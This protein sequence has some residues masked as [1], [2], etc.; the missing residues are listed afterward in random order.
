MPG[1]KAQAIS[2]PGGARHLL[3]FSPPVRSAAGAEVSEEGGK[4]CKKRRHTPLT[5]T[6][7]L[8]IIARL[9]GES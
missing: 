5:F 2:Y 3:H 6:Q 1:I 4:V 7:V 8:C 9:K